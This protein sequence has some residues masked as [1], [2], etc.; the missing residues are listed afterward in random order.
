MR[1]PRALATLL[2]FAALAFVAVVSADGRPP[3]YRVI[4]NPA[5]DASS[6]DREFLADAFLKKA[7]TWPNSETIR[8]ADLAGSSP[9]RRQFSDEVLR[10]T[11]AEVKGY[12]QQR[13]F[14]GRDV[15]PPEFDSDEEVVK[16][17][18]K[19]EGAVGYVSGAA[20][21]EGTH[22]VAVR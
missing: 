2:G 3:A 17:V 16:Y 11:V 22:V 13:I 21:L 7:T 1:R 4:V 15:P 20:N 12:W 5:N 8:P 18:L 9:V 19:Y 6:V 14:S 10:R